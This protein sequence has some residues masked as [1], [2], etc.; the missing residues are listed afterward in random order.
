MKKIRAILVK[1]AVVLDIMLT[2]V[3]AFIASL[4][5]FSAWWMFRTWKNLTMDELVFHLTGPLEGT[6]SDI[7]IEYL[8]QCILPSL[9][10]LALTIIGIVIF[11]KKKFFY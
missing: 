8:L 6:N 7:I 9:L 11:R 5:L 10:I 2:A 1:I 3:F 4:L